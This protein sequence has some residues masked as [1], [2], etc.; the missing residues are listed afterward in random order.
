[1]STYT[2]SLEISTPGRAILDVTGALDEEVKNACV[3]TGVA[4]I[5]VHHTSASLIVSEN[6]DPDVLRDLEAYLGRLVPD[7]DPLYW[8]TAEGPDD[9]AAHVRSALTLT[10]LTVPIAGGRLDLGTWQAIYLW[11]HRHRPHR[12]RLSVMVQGEEDSSTVRTK[13][14]SEP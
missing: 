5:F 8:H 7:G 1:M 10:S 14:P 6:A 12:R 13:K 3:W 11:E 9:M 4:H 2:T